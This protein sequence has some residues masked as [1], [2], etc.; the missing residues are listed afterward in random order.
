MAII[1]AQHYAPSVIVQKKPNRT[2]SNLTIKKREKIMKT[3]DKTEI[4]Y[5]S[6]TYYYKIKTWSEIKQN[7]DVVDIAGLLAGWDGEKYWYMDYRKM[8]A[9]WIEDAKSDILAAIDKIIEHGYI[10][11]GELVAIRN[12][13]L[14]YE[15]SDKQTEVEEAMEDYIRTT[16]KYE[17]TLSKWGVKA[18]KEDVAGQLTKRCSY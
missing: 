4:T 9:Q 11:D 3:Y 8:T 14:D 18:D 16:E 6:Q 7:M 13:A 10:W 17:K 2:T 12:A 5:G 1:V 15:C